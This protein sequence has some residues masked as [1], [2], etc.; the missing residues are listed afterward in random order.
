MI[1]CDTSVLVAAFTNVIRSTDVL[2]WLRD[3]ADQVVVSGWVEAEIA[4]AIALK[5]RVRTLDRADVTAALE[6]YRSFA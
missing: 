1:Y 2:S 3:H 6:N 4:S 5:E